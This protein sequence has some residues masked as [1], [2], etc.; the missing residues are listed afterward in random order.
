LE[1]DPFHLGGIAARGVE[2]AD[3]RASAGPGHE[4]D[5]HAGAMKDFEDTS[6]GP[7]LDTASAKGDAHGSSSLLGAY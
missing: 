3:E 2:R 6:V 5:R 4:V 7:S 1:G